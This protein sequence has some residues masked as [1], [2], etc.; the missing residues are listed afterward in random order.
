MQKL[1][2][3]NNLNIEKITF[4]DLKEIQE[5]EKRCYSNPWVYQ[6]LE[7][8]LRLPFA[9][10]YK[11]KIDSKIAGYC[12]CTFLSDNLHINNFCIDKKYQN[13]GNGF[14]FLKSL[15][16]EAKNKGVKIITLEVATN[17]LKALNLYEKT[18]FK[19]DRHIR[20]FYSNG[21]DA[22]RMFLVVDS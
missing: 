17:N 6:S 1:Q 19:K 9:F 14:K 8:E 13:K 20:K 22:L 10:H 21:N 5:I 15:I 7:N 4:Y 12:F 2:C 18:G 3:V 11:F 16:E